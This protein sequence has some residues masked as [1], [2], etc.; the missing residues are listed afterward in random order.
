MPVDYHELVAQLK[1]EH[2]KIRTAPKTYIPILQRQIL[3][4]RGDIIY[5]TG[6]SPFQTYEGKAAFEEAITFLENQVA[7]PEL[8]FDE[9]LCKS[10]N[11]LLKD[12]GP[13]GLTSHETSDG[14][15]LTDRIELFCEWDG[16]IAE[17]I[18]F[19]SNTAQNIIISLLVDD[20]MED[21]PHRF[22]L[23]NPDLNLFGVSCGVHSE[24]E[25]M[26]VIDYACNLRG[27]NDPPNKKYFFRVPEKKGESVNTGQN[28]FQI[29]D[30]DA[31]DNTIG[32]KITKIKKTE[33]GKEKKYCRKTYSLDN[34]ATHI[35]DVEEN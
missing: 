8:F 30:P 13:K 29:N 17:S 24:F 1:D 22:N 27:F 15:G 19:S 20:G 12:I 3:L 31:P 5:R 18:E 10:G 6:E 35:V 7:V 25:H 32:V 34:G 23:F 21:R 14:K 33:N 2:N 4:F 26:T 11:E 9:N 28:S 16:A